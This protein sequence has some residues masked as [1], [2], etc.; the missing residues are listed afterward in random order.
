MRALLGDIRYG[1][2]I[3]LKSP[4]VT[5]A[6]VLALA[7]G[8]GANTAIFSVVNT[9]L[10]RPL[11]FHDPDRLVCLRIDHQ[12]RNIQGAFT[13]YS[14]VA[15]WRQQSRSFQFLSA[16]TPSSV[17]LTTRDEPER[18]ALWRVNASFFPMFGVRMTLGRVFTQE[19]D[20]PGAGHVVILSHSL[21]QRRFGSDKNL[22]GNTLI[23]DGEPFAVVGIL[24]PTFR[25]EAGTVDLYA[26][27]ALS[28]ARSGRQ[29][30]SCG[31]YGRLKPSASIAQAQAEL[32]TINRRIDDQNPRSIRG[33]SV[34]VWGLREFM[35]RDVRLSLIILLAAVALVLL[36]ACANVANLLLARAG[37][38]QREIAIRAALGAARGRVIRQLL[39][40][41]LL[42]A[43]LGGALGVLLAYWGVDLL[44][45]L[46]AERFP[47]LAQTRLDA[48]VLGFTTLVC[49]LTG[50]LFGL[51]PALAVSRTDVHETLKEG[52]RAATET[53][54]RGL[55][56][57]ALVVFEVALALLLTIGASLMIR[58][59]LKLQQV[60][61]GFN[62][63]GVLTAS[64]NLAAPKYPKPPQQIAFY[65]RLIERVEAMPGVKAAGMVSLLPLG[66]SNQG[67]GL[68]IEGRPVSGPSDV[69]ILYF[70]IVNTRYFQAMQIPL[71]KGRLFTDQD[72]QGAPRV[73]IVN[74][75]LARRYWPNQDPL[76]KRIGNG[77]PDGWM[78]VVGVVGDVRHMSLAQEP[79]VEI[80]FPFPQN[81]RTGMTLAVRTSSDP[82]RFAPALRR[83]VLEVDK[84]QPVSRLASLE[85][86]LADSI[87]TKRFSVV[88]LGIFAAVALL[89]AAVGIYGLIS[90]TVVRR[91]HE[92]GV[93]MALGAQRDQVLRMVVGQGTLLALIG[94]GIGVIAAVI[95]TRF[96]SSLL[97]GVKAIDPLIFAAVSLLLTAVA[98]LA[99]FLPARRAARVDPMIAL[100]YE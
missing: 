21:W 62:P 88:L 63:E 15:E 45:L 32:Q 4:G 57:S 85:Q 22:V 67:L 44:S 69:P 18:V 51:A 96:I 61:P 12:Q 90:F 30:F 37:A 40:E 56:R 47:L 100:R 6:A 52:G 36:I 86:V 28:S 73:L 27:I 17:N 41:S 31:A 23:I 3:L 99:S 55:L 58:S 54:G 81:P 94:V 9:V 38:R 39:T 49:V 97:Y 59:F 26:P 92:I 95:L 75:T 71:R 25:L 93:R 11:P 5:A 65:Q 8:I 79:D 42:L 84:D 2:R 10:L 7:L 13:S 83:A 72:A 43:L 20:Q 78:A 35:V 1:L 46:R 34:H 98:A 70:R 48:T 33:W 14:S 80:Y 91:T 77:A 87:A 19:E 89:L 60:N 29:E 24:P 50:L 68:L 66:G 16:F 82:L 64:I 76:G 53:R 74:Q